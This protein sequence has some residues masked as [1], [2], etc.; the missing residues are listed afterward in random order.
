MRGIAFTQWPA[1]PAA[2]WSGLL[3]GGHLLVVRMHRVHCVGIVLFGVAGRAGSGV[4]GPLVNASWRWRSRSAVRSR[5]SAWR[6]PG[7]A[8]RLH[9]ALLED[10]PEALAV[11]LVDPD[12]PKVEALYEACGYRRISNRQRFP[13]SPNFAVMLRDLRVPASS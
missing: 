5:A 4:V 3:W 9:T 6:K 1:S 8:E 2:V 12:H 11:L 7:T 10:R 13:N